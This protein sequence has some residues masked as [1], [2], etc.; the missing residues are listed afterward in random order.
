MPS[1]DFAN[2]KLYKNKIIFKSPYIKIFITS[3][4]ILFIFQYN[5]IEEGESGSGG[6]YTAQKG[7]GW[8]NGI[9]LE[10]FNTWGMYLNSKFVPTIKPV[11]VQQNG[12]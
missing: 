7:F 12:G 1:T 2:E 9:C 6:E 11:P 8:T 4:S 10:M 3:F 5:A